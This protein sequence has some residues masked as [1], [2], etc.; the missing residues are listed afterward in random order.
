MLLV[1]PDICQKRNGGRNGTRLWLDIVIIGKTNLGM[2]SP[3]TK[4]LLRLVQWILC[5]LCEG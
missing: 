4:S 2:Y 3:M 5:P 1:T